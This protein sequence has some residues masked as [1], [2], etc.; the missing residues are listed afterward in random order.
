MHDESGWFVQAV[1]VAVGFFFLT[2]EVLQVLEAE[3]T[4]YVMTNRR[5]LILR[6]PF[7]SLRGKSLTTF[8]LD[9]LRSHEKT[10]HRNGEVTLIF[11]SALEPEAEGGNVAQ[12][13]FKRIRTYSALEPHL[14]SV[15]FAT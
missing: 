13:G 5:A 1:F 8:P 4:F 15:M 6:F 12:I 3:R 7:A 11:T 9:Q 14:K 10:V 2:R